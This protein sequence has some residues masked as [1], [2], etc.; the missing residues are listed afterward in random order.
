MSNAPTVLVV[1]YYRES[2]RSLFPVLE[3][4]QRSRGVRPV[5]LVT[6]SGETAA[7][8]IATI[9]ASGFEVAT[10]LPTETEQVAYATSNPWRREQLLTEAN[11]R[12][13]D[14]IL[15]EI[16]PEAIICTQ[17]TARAQL[18]G[19]ATRRGIPSLYVQW[20]EVHSPEFH[21][22]FRRAEIRHLDAQLSPYRFARRK[23]AR[24]LAYMVEPR[25]WWPLHTPATRLAVQGEFTRRMCL[26]AGV[27]DARLAVTGSPQ[28]DDMFHASRRNPAE[29]GEVRRS[30]GLLGEAEFLLYP[31]EHSGR[32]SHL[33]PR[34]AVRADR[35][36]ME[37]MRRGAPDLP[38][39]VKLHPK[40]DAAAAQR[41]LAA[42]PEAIVVPADV[43]VGDLIAA[44]GLVVSMTSSTLLWSVGIDRPAISAYF[45]EGV[46]EFRMTRH[47]P[48]VELVDT[49]A[50]LATAVQRH[51]HDP[52]HAAHWRARRQACCADFLRVD[53]QSVNRIVDLYNRLLDSAAP[54]STSG[55]ALAASR[56][57]RLTP[58]S[59]NVPAPFANRS[60]A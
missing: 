52:A 24:A 47:W 54:S 48:G 49:A 33:D 30:L 28:C 36:L 50:A 2:F 32:L 58:P 19:A 46:D 10:G 18:L 51:L 9:R 40:D 25:D 53:G 23:V 43:P 27:P 20:T 34:S 4:L 8:A 15:D 7:Q 5:L 29:L 41:L 11:L 17:D 39:V 38:R 12:L 3:A 6:S 59:S 60:S 44:A 55:T 1:S 21:R 13:A 56:A 42:D 31:H 26:A 35:E 14:H 37:G 57:A 16:A 45:W 22:R